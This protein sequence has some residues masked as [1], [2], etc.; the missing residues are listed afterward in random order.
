MA[1]KIDARLKKLVAKAEKVGAALLKAVES[2]KTERVG[3]A[4]DAYEV[5]IAD[6]YDEGESVCGELG[7]NAPEAD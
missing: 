1:K 7:E 4:L 6:V 3:R 5:A 2:G